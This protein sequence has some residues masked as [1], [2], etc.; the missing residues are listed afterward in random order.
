VVLLGLVSWRWIFVVVVLGDLHLVLTFFQ[1][2]VSTVQIIGEFW[3]N[4]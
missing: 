3:K 1:F 2:L 4:M